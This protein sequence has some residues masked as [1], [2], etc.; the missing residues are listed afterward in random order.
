MGGGAALP[1]LAAM[2]RFC[3]RIGEAHELLRRMAGPAGEL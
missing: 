1:T 3:R 2:Q